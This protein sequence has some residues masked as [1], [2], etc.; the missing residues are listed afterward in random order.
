MVRIERCI[1]LGLFG[2]SIYL[3]SILPQQLHIQVIT[4]LFLIFCSA[5]IYGKTCGLTAPRIR[6]WC[7]KVCFTLVCIGCFFYALHTPEDDLNWQTFEP[8]AFA[9]LYGKRPMLVEFTANWCPNCHYVESTVLTDRR[10]RRL[11]KNYGLEFIRVDITDDNPYG[12]R[13]L[14]QLGSRSI[15]VT[16]LFPAGEGAHAPVVLRDVYTG[17]ELDDAVEKAFGSP[18]VR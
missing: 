4:A 13:I 3:L 8:N 18:S 9:Q 11:H 7:G 5:Y 14:E 1:G 17:V 2:T 6:R 10:L 12:R 16:A 15:P